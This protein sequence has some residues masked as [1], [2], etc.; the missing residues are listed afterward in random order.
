M[1]ARWA[2]FED[3]VRGIASLIHG[4][5][6]APGHI[7]GVD[8]DGVIEIDPGHYILLE[9]TVRSELGKVREDILKLRTARGALMAE[10]DAFSECYCIIDGSVTQSMD[11]AA[12]AP[13][14]KVFSLESFSRIF[15][16]FVTYRLARERAPFGSAVNALDGTI[17]TN[18]Y[19]YVK[20]VSEHDGKEYDAVT[21]AKLL[22]DG[23]RI[24]LLGEYGSGKS[25][26]LR[27][28]FL[29]LSQAAAENLCYPIAIDLRESW[30]LKRGNEVIR[31][32][33]ED[34]A[35]EKLQNSALTALSTGSL[36]LLI[37]GFDEIGSQSWS[38]DGQKLKAIR[39][40][41]LQGASNLLQKSSG[42]ALIAGRDHYF[43]TSEEMFSCLGLNPSKTLVLRCKNEFSAAE[44]DFYFKERQLSFTLP[45]WLPKRPLICQTINNLD[46]EQLDEMFGNDGGE[47][48]FWHHLIDVICER[49]ARIHATFEG[50]TIKKVLTYL[51]TLTRVKSANVGPISLS[52][53]QRAFENAVGQMPIEEAAAMLQRL[54]CLGRLNSESNDRQFVDEYILDGL[55][56]IDVS[57]LAK[58]ND[59]GTKV[60]I[61]SVWINPL[62]E[63][64]LRILG[65][66][67][68][69]GSRD[70]HLL[71]TRSLSDQNRVLG[72]DIVAAMLLGEA[73]SI[74][75]K[76]LAV[77]QG[78][79]LLVDLSQV[80]ASNLSITNSY[81][82]RLIL[83]ASAPVG[84]RIAN[85]VAEKVY[86]ATS[87]SG[88]PAWI[89]DLDA[90]TYESF[91][92]VS[93]IRKM[94]LSPE[95]QVLVTIVKKTFFQKGSGRKEEAL[96]RGLG[97]IVAPPTL[98]KILALLIRE[99]C[100]GTFRGDDGTV[101]APN[102][103]FAGRMKQMLYT[104]RSSDDSIWR[105]VGEM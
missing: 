77:D 94:E 73:N 13:R 39:A 52:E 53:S 68:D 7:G 38:N 96:L 19:T 64:G 55:R 37:D 22:Q 56:A 14:V 102:R 31:R 29:Q 66:F 105:E 16:D 74:D 4:K 36:A 95:H 33:L 89:I 2:S 23:R 72:S 30:G 103:V 104:L 70:F 71:A 17:D 98:Q 67:C 28:V 60:A 6:C 10:R 8:V 65:K 45:P 44:L 9:I 3:R 41:A 47:T 5:P 81:F 93:R 43:P 54:P 101:Y 51:A 21:I 48:D 100:L 69:E 61:S 11:E 90:E 59:V 87:V 99:R 92:S 62:N 58:G 88:L 15:F 27:E 82:S 24:I 57:A 35:L 46:A 34:L 42:G 1:V 97:Q 32:H 20:Y 83:P 49:D 63:L 80:R 79:F 84:T 18:A 50:A 76:G 78:K 12:K 40:Q 75:F 85:C 25:R 26:C 86:G 91:D